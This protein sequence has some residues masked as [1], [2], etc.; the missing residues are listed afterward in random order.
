MVIRDIE[1]NKI[2]P[3]VLDFR[4]IYGRESEPAHDVLEFFDGLSDGVNSTNLKTSHGKGRINQMF[5]DRYGL[6]RLFLH[7]ER[8]AFEHPV[9]KV[10][11]VVVDPLP[12]PLE[13]VLA[14]LRRGVER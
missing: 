4:T 2:M 7:A 9:L 1:C 6:D 12:E 14:A 10:P 5:R 8:L 13:R 3:V 11:V